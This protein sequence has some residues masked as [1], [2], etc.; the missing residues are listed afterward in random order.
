MPPAVYSRIA[1]TALGVS[2]GSPH[3]QRHGA[4]TTG[5]AMLF[6]LKTAAQRSTE[7]HAASGPRPVELR[8]A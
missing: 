1:F 5:A 2:A 4:T 7:P 8:L 6:P 3:H